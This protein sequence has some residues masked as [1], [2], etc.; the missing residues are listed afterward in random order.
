LQ[1]RVVYA[2]YESGYGNTVIVQHS[3]ELQTRYGHLGSIAVRVGDAVDSQDTLGTVGS[4]GR[5][6]GPHLHFEV[7]R[8]GVAVDPVENHSVSISH[9]RTGNQKPGV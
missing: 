6:T 9:S 2:G 8:N 4:T 7:T 1:G 5:S 3:G